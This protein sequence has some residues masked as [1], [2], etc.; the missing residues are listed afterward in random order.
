MEMLTTSTIDRLTGILGEGQYGPEIQ[1]SLPVY[2]GVRRIDQAVGLH[3][4]RELNLAASFYDEPQRS[5]L[6]LT[7]GRWD[8]RNLQAL[9][10]VQS[11]RS[12]GSAV[13]D[14]LV[15][16]GRMSKATV[17]ELASQSGV[18]AMA[19][20]MMAWR[21]PT[22]AIAVSVR[23]ALP[24]FERTGDVT[25]IESAIHQGFDHEVDEAISA[26]P[27]DALSA[28]LRAERDRCNVLTAVRLR[29]ARLREEPLP[30]GPWVG[31]PTSGVVALVDDDDIESTLEHLAL[32]PAGFVDALRSWIGHRDATILAD[33]LD[34]AVLD[35]AVRAFASGPLGMGVPV[36]YVWLVENEAR[37]LRL[38]ARA[39]G[40]SLDPLEVEQ[41]MVMP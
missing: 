35:L 14:S 2:S 9:V 28:Q 41:R 38:V 37:N 10:R 30:S 5:R 4:G 25:V 8:V 31:T 12:G 27:S 20:L 33:D 6:S 16:V 39:L 34:R 1:A 19:E 7:L 11:R 32:L 3:L 18:R 15:P 21:V 40:H 36:G 29:E 22:R 13:V 24:D 23:D 26:D 17:H